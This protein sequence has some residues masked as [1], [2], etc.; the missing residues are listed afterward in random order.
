MSINDLAQRVITLA[1]SQ[2][3]RAHHLRKAYGQAFD[4]MSRR[5]PKLDKIRS[6]IEFA[7]KFKL[8]IS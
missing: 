1:G 7:P 3:H 6:V 4:D 2:R 5:V 8:E